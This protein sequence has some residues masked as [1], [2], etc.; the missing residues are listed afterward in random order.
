MV[1]IIS[2]EGKENL[3]PNVFVRFKSNTCGYC[4]NSQP[5]WDK[6][7]NRVKK[8]YNNPNVAMVEIES[9]FE[10]DYN[11]F[12]KDGSPFSSAGYPEHVLFRNNVC[13][14]KFNQERIADLFEKTLVNQ[15][16]LKER[17]AENTLVNNIENTLNKVNSRR[18]KS[19]RKKRKT[20]GTR[21][22]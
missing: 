3:P 1:F 12:N 2:V 21:R 10:N 4:I 11:F 20:A 16:N 7:C 8:K 9:A 13:V 18:K 6:A 15:F 22:K 14:H 17:T 5:E 19:R